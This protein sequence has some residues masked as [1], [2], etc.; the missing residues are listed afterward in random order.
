[1]TQVNV[2][3]ASAELE[4]WQHSRLAD[5][6][7]HIV[8][9]HHG[10]LRGELPVIEKLLLARDAIQQLTKIFRQFHREMEEHMKKEEVILFP[11]IEK[12]ESARVT[13]RRPPQLPFGSIAHPIAV[14]EQEHEMT[15]KELAEMRTLTSD[16]TTVSAI[17]DDTL[18]LEKF[19]TLEAD[20][21]IHSR[22]EDEVLFPRTITLERG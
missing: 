22:L 18:L 1:M 7:Q 8:K 15:R 16:Y 9:T 21:D 12:L 13:G 14:M 19:R 20:L 5:L 3:N 4:Q 6:I 11:M 10:Y 17:G 2:A